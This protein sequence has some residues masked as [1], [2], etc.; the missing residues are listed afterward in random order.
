MNEERKVEQSEGCWDGGRKEER[1][2][3]NCEHVAE[4]EARLVV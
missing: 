2:E 3:G 1:L 4:A